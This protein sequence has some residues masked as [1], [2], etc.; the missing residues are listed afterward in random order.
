MADHDHH[1]G[2]AG[3]RSDV[4]EIAL[5]L[6]G[7]EGRY[8]LRRC[9][10]YQWGRHSGSARID[11]H[12]T[13]V[14]DGT[15]RVKGI[16]SSDPRCRVTNSTWP[17]SDLRSGGA[18]RAVAGARASRGLRAPLDTG[19]ENNS[20]ATRRERAGC[21]QPWRRKCRASTTSSRTRRRS[22]RLSGPHTARFV[23]VAADGKASWIISSQR[24]GERD[25]RPES[26][27]LD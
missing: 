23:S 11:L 21:D 10:K 22:L 15:S 26:V 20:V 4:Y 13:E 25:H 27:E 5:S 8:G 3:Q 17:S 7:D 14:L 16:A 9:L 2:N 12:H 18:D 6:R 24:E 1:F 19:G